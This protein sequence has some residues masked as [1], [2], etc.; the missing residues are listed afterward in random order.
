MAN[1]QG[2][3]ESI[4]APL[5]MP[6]ALIPPDLTVEDRAQIFRTQNVVWRHE[7]GE[8]A[9]EVIKQ[10][11]TSEEKGLRL[12]SE[13]P[14]NF[15]FAVSRY[16]GPDGSD[17]QLGVAFKV[18]DG[19]GN[20]FVRNLGIGFEANHMTTPFGNERLSPSQYTALKG[21]PSFNPITLHLD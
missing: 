14:E 19:E 10:H 3:G 5:E 13:G 7:I 1:E 17:S 2:D 20:F 8:R 18:Q 15:L 11:L 4:E 12:V 9:I 6:L 16:S 21:L